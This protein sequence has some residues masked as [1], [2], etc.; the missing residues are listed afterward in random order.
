MGQRPAPRTGGDDNRPPRP[1]AGGEGRP[2]MPRP[3]PAMMPK[4]PAAFGNGPG[5]RPARG[6]PGGG[7]GRP[8]APGRGGAPG[9]PGAGAPV[10]LPVV[11]AASAVRWR[12]S[13][14]R[15]PRPAWPD[16]G[17]LRSPRWPVAPRSQVEAG[18]SPGVR[19]HGGPDHRRRARPQGQRRDRSPAAWCVADR[20]RREDQRRRGRPG[21]DAVL[22]RR[23]GHLDPVRR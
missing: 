20:L 9:R 19:G 11:P 13:R 6:G 14:W 12:S 15:S 18:A 17:C 23:D 7:P 3:N 22:A 16:P 21:P 5:A 4:S 10:A 1:P 2:G 8:G